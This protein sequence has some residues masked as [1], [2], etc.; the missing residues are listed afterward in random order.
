[1]EVD[2]SDM[3][4]ESIVDLRNVT[5]TAYESLATA[6]AD[7]Q[8][9]SILNVSDTAQR[10]EGSHHHL[11]P[12]W[13]VQLTGSSHLQTE[14]S[15]PNHLKMLQGDA[16]LI[17][18]GVPHTELLPKNATNIVA[19]IIDGRLCYH[20]SIGDNQCRSTRLIGEIIPLSKFR[21]TAGL[22]EDISQGHTDVGYLALVFTQLAEEL[23]SAPDPG[24][25]SDILARC[26]LH[27]E[28]RLH[29]VNLSVAGLAAE[30]GCHPDHLSRLAKSAWGMPIVRWITERRLLRAR[31]MLATPTRTIGE[32]AT[33]CGFS[34]ARYFS[35]ESLS[36]ST[37]APPAPGDVFCFEGG[38]LFRG[39]TPSNSPGRFG[40]AFGVTR[41]S[42]PAA[43]LILRSKIWADR[44]WRLY[45][46]TTRPWPVGQLRWPPAPTPI[47]LC[48]SCSLTRFALRALCTSYNARS[49]TCRP[50][51]ARTPDKGSAG[52]CA[53]SAEGRRP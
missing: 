38:L 28:H 52:E 45:P 16:L 1:M 32:I 42:R 18:S 3:V 23:R 41:R 6:T 7:G 14:E 13:F 36:A 10:Y 8:G 43:L 46:P 27:V 19:K 31:A 4:I 37:N 34:D 50:P 9:P 53:S 48:T 17:P 21:S 33:S 20:C 44:L 24:G 40:Y 39:V 15:V 30:L 25:G 11:V 26:Q 5:I 35:R 29:D 22:L 2:I 51:G 47:A 49:Q 12:E